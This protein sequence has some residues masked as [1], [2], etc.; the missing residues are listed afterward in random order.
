MAAVIRRCSTIQGDKLSKNLEYH[1]VIFCLVSV[2]R[3]QTSQYSVSVRE[4]V[5]YHEITWIWCI[6]DQGLF[7]QNKTYFQILLSKFVLSVCLII[8]I[9]LIACQYVNTSYFCQTLLQK[10]NF[11]AQKSEKSFQMPII[12]F[13]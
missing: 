10:M 13:L 1:G 7:G 4:C 3:V 6:V 9:C 8:I 12:L 11:L 2:Y 5:Y